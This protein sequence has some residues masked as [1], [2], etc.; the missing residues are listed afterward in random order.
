MIRAVGKR[1][2]REGCEAV[3]DDHEIDVAVAAVET[4]RELFGGDTGGCGCGG[5]LTL[6]V[7]MSLALSAV[8]L[9]GFTGSK[10]MFNT[11]WC[12]VVKV[13]IAL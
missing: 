3:C 8:W 5:C 6:L 2:R 9:A 1:P 10:L 7:S 13:V 4:E 11:V 12:I